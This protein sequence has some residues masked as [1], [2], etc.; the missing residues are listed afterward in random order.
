MGRLCAKTPK[1]TCIIT[2]ETAKCGKAILCDKNDKTYIVMNAITAA[3][4][5]SKNRFKTLLP[6][7]ENA[8][9]NASKYS[10]SGTFHNSGDG[11]KSV[12]IYVVTPNIKLHGTNDAAVQNA[13]FEKDTFSAPPFETFSPDFNRPPANKHKQTS[14]PYASKPADHNIRC[15]SGGTFGSIKI[16]NSAK[17]AKLPAFENE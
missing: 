7:F 8:K 2:K 12:V 1:H 9:T 3:G 6:H 16:G 5:N 11:D 4:R 10:A 15:V 17:A 14:T 13:A